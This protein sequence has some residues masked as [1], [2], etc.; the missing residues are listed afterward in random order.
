MTA[1][2]ASRRRAQLKTEFAT[3]VYSRLKSQ[4]ITFLTAIEEGMAD[5]QKWSNIRKEQVKELKVLSEDIIDDVGR[6][7][8][9]ALE[10]HCN[11]VTVLLNRGCSR[12][13]GSK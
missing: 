5:R 1:D 3:T 12:K 4:A 7:D 13:D 10:E 9:K 8:H 2:S 11:E 6:L